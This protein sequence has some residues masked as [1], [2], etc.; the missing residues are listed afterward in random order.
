MGKAKA[1]NDETYCL[2]RDD[3]LKLT[4]MYN[5]AKSPSEYVELQRVLVQHI[6][7]IEIQRREDRKNKPLKA[8]WIDLHCVGDAIAWDIFHP[9]VIRQMSSVG[10]KPP[11]IIDQDRTIAAE[12][13]MIQNMAS[14]DCVGLIADITNVAQIGDIV[15]ESSDGSFGVIECKLEATTGS[16]MNGA[17]QK[18]QAKRV[19]DTQDYLLSGTKRDND[20]GVLRHCVELPEYGSKSN[21]DILDECVQESLREGSSIKWIGDSEFIISVAVSSSAEDRLQGLFGDANIDWAKPV[22]SCLTSSDVLTNT[23]FIAPVLSRK[24]SFESR[25][26]MF[27]QEVMVCHYLDLDHLFSIKSKW[28]RV[29][30]E[31]PKRAKKSEHGDFRVECERGCVSMSGR[32]FGRCLHEMM[33]M[34]SC[35]DEMS[36]AAIGFIDAMSNYLQSE[37]E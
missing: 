32:V 17:R 27:R 33:T 31:V 26:A 22:Y 37:E 28:G 16:S 34:E 3:W 14:N 5:L 21:N 4:N 8:D 20:A 19:I 10:M 2:S 18:R 13:M 24:L 1:N 25:F 15:I 6:Q 23:T 30:S 7:R 12:L 29:I 35:V 36:L 11:Y 9:H